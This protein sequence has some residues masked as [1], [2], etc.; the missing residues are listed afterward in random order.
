MERDESVGLGWS[1]FPA[2]VVHGL[3]DFCILA[4]AFFLYVDEPTPEEMDKASTQVQKQYAVSE[5]MQQLYGFA[6]G[7]GITVMA[8]IYYAVLARRQRHRLQALEMTAAV[9]L[10]TVG[11]SIV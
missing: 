4:L 5:A 11:R 7:A 9:P 2:V 8:L 1:V 10:T 6:I 3:F